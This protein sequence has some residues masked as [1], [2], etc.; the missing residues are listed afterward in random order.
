MKWIVLTFCFRTLAFFFA[1]LNCECVDQTREKIPIHA[2]AF[3]LLFRAK[4][5]SLLR[6]PF[7]IV[8]PHLLDL[9]LFYDMASGMRIIYFLIIWPNSKSA[10]STEQFFFLAL[11]K[12]NVNGGGNNSR[13]TI[14]L[15][16][17]SKTI[18]ITFHLAAWQD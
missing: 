4:E 2:L 14:I 3:K 16:P 8:N 9:V 13:H 18:T 12:G 5:S 6:Y 11:A 15:M 1:S 10:A 17:K 7:S